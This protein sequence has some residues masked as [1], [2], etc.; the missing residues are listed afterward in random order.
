M[1]LGSSYLHRLVTGDNAKVPL[2]EGL[3]ERELLTPEGAGFDLRIGELFGFPKAIG[4]NFGTNPMELGVKTRETP[5]TI[6]VPFVQFKQCFDVY[7][8][9]MKMVNGEWWELEPRTYYLMRT[10]ESVHLPSD[11]SA[12]FSPRHTLYS[13]GILFNSGNA[14]PGYGFKNGKPIEAKLVF[15]LYNATDMPGYIEKGARICFAEFS[16][17]QDHSQHANYRGQWAQANGRVSCEVA[18]KQV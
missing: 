18:E 10:M 2:V 14:A 13:S 16:L 1:I 3:C 11:I 6:P 9:S 8:P 4:M 7:V 17:I 5:K 15:G 12:R